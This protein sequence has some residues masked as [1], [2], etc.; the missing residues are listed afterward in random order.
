MITLF[1]VEVN[2]KFREWAVQKARVELQWLMSHSL[3][4]DQLQYP[5]Q[6]AFLKP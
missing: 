4:A 5:L 2:F 3:F 6:P 1:D